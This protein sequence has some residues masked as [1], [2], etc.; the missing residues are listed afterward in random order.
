MEP[1]AEKIM[2]TLLWDSKAPILQNYILRGT[3]VNNVYYRQ[4]LWDWLRPASLMEYQG[5][6]KKGVALLLENFN[7]HTAIHTVHTFWTTELQG[8]GASSA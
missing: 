7:L 1:P 8:D 4:M 2:P 6:V 3:T 5:M